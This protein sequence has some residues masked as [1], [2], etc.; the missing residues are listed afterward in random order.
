MPHNLYLHSALVQTRAVD[1][2]NKGKR[3]ACRYN[4]IDTGLALNAAFV[5]NAAILIVA[6][7]VFFRRGIVVTQIQQAHEC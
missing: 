6:A 7:A 3:D 5:V 4:L 1:Q 2:S